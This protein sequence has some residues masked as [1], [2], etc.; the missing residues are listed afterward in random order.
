MPVMPP[1]M[2]CLLPFWL[3]RALLL[4]KVLSKQRMDTLRYWDAMK[5]LWDKSSANLGKKYVFTK[6][7]IGFR[8]YPSCGGTLGVLD[9]AIYLRNR[10]KIDP[11][12]IDSITLGVGPFE[13][14]TL[15]H[16]PTKGLEGKDSLEYCTCRA[17]ID[18]KVTL[19]DFTDE[20]VNQPGDQVINTSHQMRGK[21]SD[22]RNGR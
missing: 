15:I 13:N 10:Y 14:G 21:V 22:G 4:M 7:A 1:L 6:S 3:N 11:S 12:R 8:S 16:N 17:L 2:E 5:R 20:K 19:F 9:S 18:G